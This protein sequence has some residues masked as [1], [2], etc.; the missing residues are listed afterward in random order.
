MVLVPSD[1]NDVARTAGF[2]PRGSVAVRD[3]S[4]GSGVLL[5]R[6]EE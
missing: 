1:P 2:I 3:E 4:R 5:L 6:A